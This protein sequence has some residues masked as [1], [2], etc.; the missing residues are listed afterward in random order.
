M[1]S[2]YSAYDRKTDEPVVIHGTAKEC[3]ERLNVKRS[4]FFH[5][6]THTRQN[7]HP[8]RKYDVYVDDPEEEDYE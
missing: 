1:A 8:R 3:M 4:T 7:V 2:Y 5:Y 6:V